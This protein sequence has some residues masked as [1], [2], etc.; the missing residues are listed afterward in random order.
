MNA[1]LLSADAR[2]AVRDAVARLE[3]HTAAEIVVAVRYRSASYRHTDYLVGFASAL[4]ALCAL[5][6]LP[7]EFDIITWPLEVTLGFV[8][9]AVVCAQLPGLKRIF[10][11][12]RAMNDEVARAAR[13][14]FVDL[15]VTRTRAR[16]GILVYVSMLEHRVEIVRDVGL[17][18]LDDDEGWRSALQKL[19]A[20]I[21]RSG[22]DGF[23]KA[24]EGLREPLARLLPRTEDDVNE[25][26]DGVREP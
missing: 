8:A 23:E 19:E 9:G 4:A 20:S 15:G 2:A 1:T 3:R 16:S 21:R 5:L 7:Q 25:L 6:F 10:T 17:D 22:R 14:A 24:L 26:A 18:V 11:S 13:A 12:R